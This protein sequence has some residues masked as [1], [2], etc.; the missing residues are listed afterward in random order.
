MFTAIYRHPPLPSP[1]PS[2]LHI[3]L[4]SA[5][6][7]TG[8]CMIA[9]ANPINEEAPF[10]ILMRSFDDIAVV[11]RPSML[12]IRNLV[13]VIGLLLAVVIAVGFR[14]LALERNV[15]RRTAAMALSR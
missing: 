6:R 8:V 10:E 15:R 9:D 2:M 4:G 12:N 5:I 13:L 1:L 3:P 11:A 7:V 14:S